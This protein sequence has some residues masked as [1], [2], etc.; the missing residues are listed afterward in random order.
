MLP[1]A[2]QTAGPNWLTFIFNMK[3]WPGGVIG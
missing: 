2:V 1:I 3:G